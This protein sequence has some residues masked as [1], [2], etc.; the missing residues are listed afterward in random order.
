M[1]KFIQNQLNKHDFNELR[2]F[3]DILDQI[4]EGVLKWA[5]LEQ[6]IELKSTVKERI[7][8]LLEANK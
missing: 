7:K 5:S 2:Q 4:D 3:Q 8:K 6:L 1:E